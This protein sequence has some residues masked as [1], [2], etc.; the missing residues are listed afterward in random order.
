MDKKKPKFLRKDWNKKSKLGRKRKQKQ[1][2]RKPKGRH[3]KL[4]Q[5]FKGKSRRPSIGYGSDWIIRGKIGGLKPVIVNNIQ[6]LLDSRNH[7]NVLVMIS[8]NVGNFKKMNIIKKALEMGINIANVDAEKFLENIEKKKDEKRKEQD[9]KRE[10]KKQE[11]K[12]EKKEEVK[13]QVVK[14][15]G[16]IEQEKKEEEKMEIDM[17]KK[18]IHKHNKEELKHKKEQHVPL[19]RTALEK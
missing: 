7:K 14:T 1:V 4:R 9:I 12:I 13:D 18:E 8:G 5:N 3:N 6:E 11:E 10:K 19:K 16:K 2:W 17:S 15:E